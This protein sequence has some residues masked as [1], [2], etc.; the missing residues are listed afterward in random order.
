VRRN[1]STLTSPTPPPHWGLRQVEPQLFAAW[2]RILARVNA[3]TPAG[4]TPPALWLLKFPK[5][6][7]KRLRQQVPRR[8][9]IPCCAL[10]R[11]AERP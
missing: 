10:L 8:A 6:A 11:A 1:G 2:A 3:S 5:E 4:G 7:V 9:R